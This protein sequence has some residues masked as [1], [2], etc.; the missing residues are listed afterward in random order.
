[1]GAACQDWARVQHG[2]LLEITCFTSRKVR[3]LTPEELRARTG[4]ACNTGTCSR[5]RLECR[6]GGAG[7]VEASRAR[8]SEPHNT[9]RC[10]YL[11]QLLHTL[12]QLC[13]SSMPHNTRRRRY[14]YARV[15]PPKNVDCDYFMLMILKYVRT[16]KPGLRLFC[17]RI[18]TFVLVKQASTTIIVLK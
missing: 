13:C 2:D 3:I 17:V 1:M 9:R 8:C 5:S 12:L 11:L 4:R 18:C 14:L 6:A 16:N 7:G 15:P 10:Q